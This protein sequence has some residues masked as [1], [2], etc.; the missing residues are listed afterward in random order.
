MSV[1]DSLLYAVTII[2]WGSTWIGIKFQLGTVDPMVSVVYRLR[3]PRLFCWC[4]VK[5]GV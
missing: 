2:I 1:K 3:F 4:S 5:S